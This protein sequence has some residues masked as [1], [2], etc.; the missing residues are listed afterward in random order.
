M[1]LDEMQLD[2][3]DEEAAAL[4]RLLNRVIADDRYPLSLRI[5][6]AARYSGKVAGCVTGTAPA[7]PPTPDERNPGRRLRQGR[8]SR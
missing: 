4:L 8:R 1:Q 3:S 6:F 5:R 7:R 2:L